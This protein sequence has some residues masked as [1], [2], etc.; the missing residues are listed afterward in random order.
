M[1]LINE[2]DNDTEKDIVNK[3]TPSPKTYSVVNPSHSESS[4][5]MENDA[6]DSNT[7][8]LPENGKC[9]NAEQQIIDELP[10][11]NETLNENQ[12]VTPN[13]PARSVTT[14]DVPS[15]TM[16]ENAS[17]KPDDINQASNLSVGKGNE[18]PVKEIG[19]LLSSDDCSTS[20]TTD[21]LLE[22]LGINERVTQSPVPVPVNKVTSEDLISKS[23]G[24][25]VVTLPGNA[26]LQSK[27]NPVDLKNE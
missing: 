9:K 21:E 8:V 11:A 2:V 14:V 5:D 27:V 17:N 23:A 1:D 6:T 19:E 26:A 13:R 10:S 25:P 24:T 12:K 4:S 3:D 20:N 7:L 16:S 18:N 15:D 22:E